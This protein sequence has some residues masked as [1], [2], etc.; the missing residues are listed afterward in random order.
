M[1]KVP[2]IFIINFF[3]GYHHQNHSK[4]ICERQDRADPHLICQIKKLAQLISVASEFPSAAWLHFDIQ[5]NRCLETNLQYD[6]DDRREHSHASVTEK[7]GKNGIVHTSGSSGK[8]FKFLRSPQA[9]I[10]SQVEKL[11]NF[12][13]QYG[14]NRFDRNIYMR[15]CTG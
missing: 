14:V 15:G 8:Q 1:A 6:K 13:Q 11:F 7:A 3:I 9:F 5:K 10:N 4:L 12:F 2:F